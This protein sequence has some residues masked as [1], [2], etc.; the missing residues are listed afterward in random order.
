[1]RLVVASMSEISGFVAIEDGQFLK[2]PAELK[3]AKVGDKFTITLQCTVTDTYV[4]SNANR[5]ERIDMKFDKLNA[6][7]GGCDE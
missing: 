3:Y 7:S 1:M 4:D 2:M 5:I 6:F